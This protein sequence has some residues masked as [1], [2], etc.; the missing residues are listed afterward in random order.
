MTASDTSKPSPW[1]V[2]CVRHRCASSLL[3]L[4]A[5]NATAQTAPSTLEFPLGK[6]G[7]FCEE[8][9]YPNASLRARAQGASTIRY[10][11]NDRSEIV[12]AVILVSAGDTREHKLLD[13]SA[14]AM[15]RSC[16]YKADGTA[17]PGSFDFEQRWRIR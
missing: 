2:P 12:H 7:F 5:M 11:V 8:P 3:A 14:L 16:R 4:V 10:T 9:Y 13:R 1:R 15:V 6:S 17:A